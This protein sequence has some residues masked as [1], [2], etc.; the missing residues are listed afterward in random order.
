MVQL[1]KFD[2]FNEISSK[3]KIDISKCTKISLFEA[4]DYTAKTFNTELN[5]HI[6]KFKKNLPV[7]LMQL[8]LDSLKHKY[9]EEIENGYWYENVITKSFTDSLNHYGINH[10][11]LWESY[12][13]YFNYRAM[14]FLQEKPDLLTL[15][16]NE[17][18]NVD[19]DIGLL[20]AS[21]INCRLK[22]TE[23]PQLLSWKI[24]KHG[25]CETISFE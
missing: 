10:W 13:K 7:E 6:K 18:I 20:F 17:V 16:L 23:V 11:K 4:I 19:L 2:I 1:S 8:M 14:R 12:H 22:V 21:T 5:D 9:P 3:K 25:S 15:P 24:E